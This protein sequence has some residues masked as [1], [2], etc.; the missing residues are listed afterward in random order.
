MT[1]LVDP[2]KM[3][4]ADRILLSKSDGFVII[5]DVDVKTAKVGR[6]GLAAR[7]LA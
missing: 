3:T 4:M 2:R 7:K 5:I 1:V 6:L